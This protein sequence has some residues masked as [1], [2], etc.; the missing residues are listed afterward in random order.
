MQRITEV[1]SGL[2][3]L[4]EEPLAT[5]RGTD[6]LLSHGLQWFNWQLRSA[7]VAAWLVL[8]LPPGLPAF[9]DR[10]EYLGLG[11]NGRNIICI[12]HGL[13]GLRQKEYICNLHESSE[14]PS[15]PSS[16]G[17]AEQLAALTA[18]NSPTRAVPQDSAGQ[19]ARSSQDFS[20]GAHSA[21]D[22]DIVH[23]GQHLTGAGA[24]VAVKVMPRL[25]A[26]LL[27]MVHNDQGPR[28]HLLISAEGSFPPGCTLCAYT[29]QGY[30]Q[31]VALSGADLQ[32]IGAPW[33]LQDCS[34][35]VF[36]LPVDV[37]SAQPPIVLELG[38]NGLWSPCLELPVAPQMDDFAEMQRH[39]SADDFA[40]Y[41][42]RVALLHGHGHWPMS[43]YP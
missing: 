26:A 22:I 40:L 1:E 6:I 8:I 43:E 15:S 20:D 10:G 13:G 23:C 11:A 27:V 9:T 16:V 41:Q 24:G 34:H 7:F 35:A 31:M 12:G 42:Q 29:Q 33:L 3:L 38:A 2:W 14:H 17:D 21:A 19:P 37:T 36:G 32:R 4:S 30:K 5:A 25:D 18:M 39:L 28:P